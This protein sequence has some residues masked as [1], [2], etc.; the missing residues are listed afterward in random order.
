MKSIV[1]FLFTVF[2]VVLSGCGAGVPGE[3]PSKEEQLSEY[4]FQV[5]ELEGKIALLEEELNQ[6]TSDH[7]VKVRLTELEPRLFEHFIEAVG[8]VHT[9]QNVVVSAETMGVITSIEVKEG[10]R[11]HKG[12]VLARLKTETI[13][14][15]IQE[16]KVNLALAT[17][18]FERRKILWDQNIGSEVEFLQAKS[19]K[20]ALTQRLE[21]MEAQLEMAVIKAPVT[22]VVD[23]LIQNQGEMA[24]PSIPFARVVNLDEV[25]ITAAV[26]E[27]YLNRI[28]AGDSVWVE[29][30]VLGL[31]RSAIIYRT[32]SVIDPD[33]RSFNVRVNLSNRDNRL[34][35]NLMAKLKMRT[36]RVSNALIVPSILVKRDFDGDFI[37]VGEAN[38]DGQMVARKR[39]I[40]T[41]EKDNNRLVV[42]SGL[43]S[44]NQLISEGF[45]QVVDGSLLNVHP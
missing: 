44:G 33:S 6:G 31:E 7:K 26:A 9:D 1:F 41:G 21:G 20:E 16:L 13:E 18:L 14:R 17:T 8:I 2:L 19:E 23:D 30:P 36:L 4:K 40:T 39:Y 25:Y 24:G 22:G 28:R 10:Q 11:V 29:V 32:S 43:D 5:K 45:A 35:P 27:T 37:F 12:Q 34:Q 15:S 3:E 42:T 38:D